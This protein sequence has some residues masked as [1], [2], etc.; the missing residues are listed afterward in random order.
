MAFSNNKTIFMNI[1]FIKKLHS[2]KGFLL[3]GDT[4]DTLYSQFVHQDVPLKISSNANG[5]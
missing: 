5:T 3:P 2:L 1:L 4:G